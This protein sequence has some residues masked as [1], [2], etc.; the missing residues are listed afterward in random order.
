MCL[1][2]GAGRQLWL[3]SWIAE[4]VRELRDEE[5]LV[6]P[7]SRHLEVRGLRWPKREGTEGR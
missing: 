7:E 3:K 6:I 1:S 5:G 4:Y 2:V